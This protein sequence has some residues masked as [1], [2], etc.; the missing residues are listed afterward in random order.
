MPALPDS[1]EL[2]SGFVPYLDRTRQALNLRL[3]DAPASDILRPFFDRGKM[4]RAFLVFAAA[5]AVDSDPQQVVM[6][7]EAIELLHLASLF[8]DDIIDH[9]AWRRGLPSLHEQLDLGKALVVGD[10]LLLRAFSALAQARACHPPSLVLEAMDT[11]NLLALQCCRGQFDELCAPRWIS[12][13]TYLELIGKKTAAP[14]AAAGALGVLLGG[15]TDRQLASIR[16][17][18]HQVGIAFQIEDDLLDL[19]GEASSMGKP[20]GNSLAHG[21][22]LLPLIC[23]RQ[24]ISHATVQNKLEKLAENG[25]NPRDLLGLM[26]EYGVLDRVMQ[27]R[28]RHLDAAVAALVDFP[29][30]AGVD[31]LRALAARSAITS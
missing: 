30:M 22:P 21:R 1:R 24:L 6:A 3:S 5:A 2:P 11:L 28:Q 26:E 31:G 25:W 20:V 4:L 7:A 27:T 15:G 19:T 23:L 29:G 13:E 16:I 9:A 10:D 14:F 17:Y 12:E 8:H 18:G